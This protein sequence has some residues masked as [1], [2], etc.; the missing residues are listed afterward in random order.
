[1]SGAHHHYQRN[2]TGPRNRKAFKRGQRHLALVMAVMKEHTA[3]N[4]YAPRL[5]AFQIHSFLP[6]IKPRTIAYYMHKAADIGEAEAE[7]R[8]KGCATE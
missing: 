3:R 5:T 2:Y 7:L 6:D 4:P 8:E 1:M